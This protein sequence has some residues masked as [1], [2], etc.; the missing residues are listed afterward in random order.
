[1]QAGLLFLPQNKLMLQHFCLWLNGS[2]LGT[3]IRQSIWVFPII[4]TVHVL[5]ITVLV[6]SVAIFDLRL[7]GLFFKREPVW[8]MARQLLPLTW[9]GFAVMF[10]SGFLLFAAEATDSYGNWAFRLKVLLL[11]LAGL[12]PLVFHLTIYRRVAAW[13]EQAVT[14][15][16]ARLAGFFSLTL[17][18]SII[19]AGR[20]IAYVQQAS[21]QK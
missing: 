4:E 20:A 17:W 1:M 6:G 5:G 15:L 16:R 21:I 14:P 11:L 7:L 12:N 18:A 2:G 19:C 8:Q 13:G 3:S 9:A 10:V